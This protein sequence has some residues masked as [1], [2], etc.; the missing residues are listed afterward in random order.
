M[1]E[2]VLFEEGQPVFHVHTNSTKRR[3]LLRVKNV[4]LTKRYLD[5]IAEYKPER[6]NGEN[7]V[8]M[9]PDERRTA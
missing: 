9:F 1:G 6:M 4:R 3:K 5:A 2:P 8:R 7:I